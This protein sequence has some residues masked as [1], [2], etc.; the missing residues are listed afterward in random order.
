MFTKLEGD[1]VSEK[2]FN[3]CE[4]QYVGGIHPQPLISNQLKTDKVPLNVKSRVLQ[5]VRNE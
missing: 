3:A 1:E 2:Q 4:I 5:T